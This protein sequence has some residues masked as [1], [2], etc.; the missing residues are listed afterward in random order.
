MSG[1]RRKP[2]MAPADRHF[3]VGPVA[4]GMTDV[5]RMFELDAE[6]AASVYG[7]EM[8][9]SLR[10]AGPQT[11]DGVRQLRGSQVFQVLLE[12]SQH[13]AL[14]V[15][16]RERV[17]PSPQAARK[18]I[19]RYYSHDLDHRAKDLVLA[20][21][22]YL[23]CREVENDVGAVTGATWSIIGA[24]IDLVRLATYTGLHFEYGVRHP[25]EKATAK[26]SQVKSERVAALLQ[27]IEQGK[28]RADPKSVALHRGEKPTSTNRERARKDL[29]DV[30]KLRSATGSGS[31]RRKQ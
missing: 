27:A 26:R 22:V 8:G 2:L 6:L 24:T 20:A 9:K 17:K 5:M 10:R 3:K 23:K 29:L 13:H 31:A 7:Q 18:I 25:T 1:K 14:S 11:V 28:V 21:A 19:A 30:A 15:F 16:S 12:A 4:G